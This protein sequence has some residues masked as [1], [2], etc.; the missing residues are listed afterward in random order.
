MSEMNVAPLDR[1][2]L[3]I[4]SA[5]DPDGTMEVKAVTYELFAESPDKI[6][7]WMKKYPRIKPNETRVLS[8]A[9]INDEYI[10]KSLVWKWPWD[11]NLLAIEKVEGRGRVSFEHVVKRET[12]N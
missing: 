6:E 5:P 8:L 2:F 4:R 7:S 9:S 1:R 12:Q 3:I 11:M 10:E